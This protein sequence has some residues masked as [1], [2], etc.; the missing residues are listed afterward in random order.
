MDSLH[1]DGERPMAHTDSAP[2]RFAA[3]ILREAL[4]D[5][6]RRNVRSP[7]LDRLTE[8]DARLLARQTLAYLRTRASVESPIPGWRQVRS[9]D[10]GVNRWWNQQIG[11]SVSSDTAARLRKLR[12]QIYDYLDEDLALI[13]K[14]PGQNAPIHL[15]PSGDVPAGGRRSDMP[16]EITIGNHG[17]GF[18]DAAKNRAVEE[19]AM[20]HVVEHYRDWNH[21]DVSAHKVGWD[22][23]MTR[24]AEERHVE[25]K[26]VSGRR[27]TVLLTNNEIRH[28]TNDPLW[29]LVV[30][31]QALIAPTIH[32]FDRATVVEATIPYVYRAVLDSN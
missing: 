13:S 22:I 17:A 15:S 2:S 12:A 26:G 4:A 9:F 29:S 30:V 31:T 19:A 21:D 23:T 10:A 3:D 32:E 1:A 24:N 11:S 27:P 14:A 20:R 25:V 28:A 5:A 18:G 6:D 16:H 8:S 7:T